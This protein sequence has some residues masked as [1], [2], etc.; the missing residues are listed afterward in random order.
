MKKWTIWNV[1]ARKIRQVSCFFFLCFRV[2]SE[3][4]T[5]SMIA[6]TATVTRKSWRS[7][8]VGNV[9]QICICSLLHLF[10]MIC[11]VFDITIHTKYYHN[12]LSLILIY[13]ITLYASLLIHGCVCMR[14]I[15]IYYIYVYIHNTLC[16]LT[17][18]QKLFQVGKVLRHV[19]PCLVM[20]TCLRSSFGAEAATLAARFVA[21]GGSSLGPCGGWVVLRNLQNPK[22]QSGSKWIQ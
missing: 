4:P 10:S 7:R 19:S 5:V 2:L 18:A 15:Y 9:L 8:Q 17:L 13:H 21:A 3:L 1:K 20:S 14:V 12:I 11:R 6:W 22:S 16:T